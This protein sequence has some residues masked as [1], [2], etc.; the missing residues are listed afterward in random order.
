MHYIF[1]HTHQTVEH[2]AKCQSITRRKHNTK[3]ESVFPSKR[4][5]K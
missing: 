3:Y 4:E 5:G 1:T 2:L